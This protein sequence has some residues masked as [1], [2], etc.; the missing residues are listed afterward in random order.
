MKLHNVDSRLEFSGVGALELP[1][2]T[3]A[4]PTF[5]VV[6][7]HNVTMLQSS[8]R[9][10]LGMGSV[11][12]AD[13][14]LPLGTSPSPS[15]LG[16][17]GAGSWCWSSLFLLFRFVPHF[18]SLSSYFLSLLSSSSSGVVSFFLFFCC[19]LS[20][21]YSFVLFLLSHSFCLSCFRS[22]F[23]GISFLSFL[24]LRFPFPS[25]FHVLALPSLFFSFVSCSVVFLFLFP[26]I[27]S[28]FRFCLSL[29]SPL[30]PSSSW[31]PCFLFLFQGCFFLLFVYSS[32]LVL[33]HRMLPL[34][35]FS[36]LLLPLLVGLQLP[37]PFLFLLLLFLP[38]VLSLP[39]QTTRHV[40]WACLLNISL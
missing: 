34:P 22:F 19:L 15:P 39:W 6:L 21:C 18:S 24:F 10:Y 16:S 5:P 35:P 27:F 12:A 30:C 36:L 9:H 31:I 20:S 3:S 8:A 23:L 38:W 33:F 14:A 29:L 37:L 11:T 17:S 25:S 2:Q 40:C 26:F 28:S 32:P 7:S 4:I 1:A 13:H